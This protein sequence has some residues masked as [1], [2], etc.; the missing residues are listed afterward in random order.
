MMQ[1]QNANNLA[2]V[3]ST[4]VQGTAISSE[5]AARLTALVQRRANEDDVGAPAGDAYKGQS[6]GIIATLTDL[7]EKSQAQLKKEYVSV[8]CGC[9]WCVVVRHGGCDVRCCVKWRGV[10]GFAKK[11]DK[12][13]KL[14][15]CKL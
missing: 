11:E 2:D 13:L 4:L 3:L 15:V 8:L 5:D 1:L 14:R 6:G 12:S 9:L 10:D 7:L